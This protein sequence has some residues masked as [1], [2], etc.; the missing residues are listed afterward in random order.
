M[1]RLMNYAWP[2]NIRELQNIIER[3][4]V[5][6]EGPTLELAQDLLP[7]AGQG[8][9]PRAPGMPR[10]NGSA[11]GRG[12]ARQV[13]GDLATLEEVERQH[14]LATLERTGGVIEGP[15][16]A[17]KILRLHPNTLRSRMEKLGI[18]FRRAR[19]ELS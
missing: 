8:G 4:V 9:L 19:S 12:P 7:V 10:E 17:A 11:A 14:I 16:G 6:S 15:Q 1:E 2:G 18:Q 3:A 13:A 5:L